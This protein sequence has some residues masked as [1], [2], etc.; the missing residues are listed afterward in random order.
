MRKHVQSICMSDLRKQTGFLIKLITRFS[1]IIIQEKRIFRLG[2]GAGL[3]CLYSRPPRHT[4]SVGLSHW[5]P[6]QHLLC[7][8]LQHSTLRSPLAAHASCFYRSADPRTMVLSAGNILNFQSSLLI[9]SISPY[10][11]PQSNRTLLIYTEPVLI[12]SVTTVSNPVNL[13]STSV[14]GLQHI[15][16]L[17]T[18]QCFC[19]IVRCQRES[20]CKKA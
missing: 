11:S 7:L 6:S 18:Y 17:V 20:I 14:K 19:S 9:I 3:C 15:K 12:F 4:F 10:D 8:P 1:I 16:T 2:N 5:P 13:Q